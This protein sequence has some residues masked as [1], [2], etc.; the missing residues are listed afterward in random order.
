M[1]TFLFGLEKTNPDAAR[2]WLSGD[3]AFQ[4]SIRAHNTPGALFQGP[5]CKNSTTPLPLRIR[6]PRKV[7]KGNS[8][9]VWYV[10]GK[11]RL[12][13]H[14]SLGQGAQPRSWN[15]TNSYI[16]KT[17]LHCINFILTYM[18]VHFRLHLYL[19]Y[20]PF[21]IIYIYQYCWS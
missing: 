18:S 3:K 13:Q 10:W 20:Q 21:T 12:C 17:I 9:Y 14:C 8:K 2:N 5:N 7:K 1:S 19:S 6:K 16:P 4:Q 11:S 15:Q